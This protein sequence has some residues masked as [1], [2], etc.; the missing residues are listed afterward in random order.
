MLVHKLSLGI[1]ASLLSL[2]LAAFSAQLK[3]FE[4]IDSIPDGW[5][6]GDCTPARDD[7]I[8]LQIAVRQQDKHD[9]LEQRLL[10]VSTPGHAFYGRHYSPEELDELLQPDPAISSAIL[11][12]LLNT[13]IPECHIEDKGDWFNVDATVAQAENL[14][15]TKFEFFHNVDNAIPP[16]I[17]TLQ[18]SVPQHLHQH[19]QMIQPT[20]HFSG[21]RPYQVGGD[22]AT[23]LPVYGS[24]TKLNS[25]FCNTT[26]SPDCIR[27]LYKIGDFKAN[28]T[29]GAKLGISGFN[30]QQAV[31]ND[32]KLFL[33]KWAPAEKG[34]NFSVKTSNRGINNETG[35]QIWAKEG[36][37]DIQYG[38]SLAS[39]IPVTF[40]KT[41]G[42]GPLIPDLQQP[43][44]SESLLVQEPFLE[45]LQYLLNLT[46]KD[47]PTVLSISYGEDEQSHPVSYMKSVCQ[48]FAKL[49][50]RGVSVIVSR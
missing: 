10:D 44:S 18:Y 15:D 50:A 19:I 13:D 39:G 30:Y 28:T 31:H 45:H 47:L 32:L 40:Y 27:A 49:G 42:F 48:L 1:W 37:L 5:Y 21:V 9:L 22:P 33:E 20:T 25:T 4:K 26:T 17:R 41:G 6:Q 8:R 16:R 43:N 38:V 34:A 14:L 46:Q 12:W 29:S 7:R 23:P 36:N 3:V 2:G 24:P 35:A 11:P